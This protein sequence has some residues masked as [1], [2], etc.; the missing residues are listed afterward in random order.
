MQTYICIFLLF[1]L[2]AAKKLRKLCVAFVKI[3]DEAVKLRYNEMN[4]RKKRIEYE[5]EK[6]EK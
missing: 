4:K 6:T 5:K 2:A 1:P 3:I